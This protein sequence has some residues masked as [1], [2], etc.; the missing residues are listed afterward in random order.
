MNSV[1]LDKAKWI[2]APQEQP[3]SFSN[4]WEK[5]IF[6]S[7][8][9]TITPEKGMATFRKRF[10]CSKAVKS[11]S[12]TVT[13]LGVFDAYINGERVG[14][15]DSGG[16]ITYEEFKPGWTDYTKR[17]LSF[18]YDI[19]G[20]I[21]AGDNDIVARVARGWYAGRISF[22]YYGYKKRALL[23]AITIEY[24][25]G[26]SEHICSGEDWET[27][28]AG[29]V[30]FAEI[31]DGEYYDARIADCA[32]S[33]DGVT[34]AR[35]ELNADFNGEVTPAEEPHIRVRR[36]L[37][38]KPETAVLYNGVI[39]D[40]TDFGSINIKKT[41]AGSMC[42]RMRICKGDTLLLDFGQNMVGR[43]RFTLKAAS[44][45]KATVY[46]AEL[47]NDSGEL[48]RKNDGPKGSA[49]I[50]NYRTA[51]S[52]IVYIA[53]GEPAGEEYTPLYTFFG[54]RYIE[55][56]A[57][58]DLELCSITGEVIGSDTTETSWLITSN[59]EI[60]RLYSNILWG[61]R[62]NY[63][64]IPTDC[65]QRDE[66]LGWTGDTQI[67]CGAAAYNADV[68]AFFKKWLRDARDSQSE[69]GG[70]CDVIPRVFPKENNDSNA[71]WG[72]AG[73]IVPYKVYQAYGDKT[74][75][76]EHYPSMEKYMACLASYGLDGLHNAYGDW[77]AYE[78]TDRS[79]ISIACYAH[80]AQLMEKMSAVLSKTPGDYYD[81]RRAEYNRLF[82]DLKAEFACRFIS[83]G[84]LKETS[85]TAYLMAL[86]FN[87]LPQDM[88]PQA[89]AQL[90][91]KLKDNNYTLSTGFV[92]TGIINQTLSQYGLDG[93]AYSLLLQT[94]DPSWLYSVR[95]GATTIWERWNSY[96]LERG[97]GDVVMN[98]FNHYAYGAVCEW[99]FESMA[100]IA[101]DEQ[102]PGYKHFILSPRP[103]TRNDAELPFGQERITYVKAEYNSRAGLIKSSWEQKEDRFTYKAS[104]PQGAGATVRLPLAGQGTVLV[105]GRA[106]GGV[107]ISGGFAVF[108]LGAGEYTMETV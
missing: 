61:Q 89:V 32:K 97:F 36:G 107:T 75:I 38:R 99:M 46:F 108:E 21:T 45:V 17:V 30:M 80:N 76:S 34:W 83:G 81:T 72:D 103:D 26:S 70:Y 78:P 41:A 8:A 71:A 84:E 54:F 90:E 14:T 101:K 53:N 3:V 92:G 18:T 33:P 2:S 5:G 96:T 60:N 23:A 35:A 39:A 6:N 73:V 64:S 65:P 27:A 22:G 66:R 93:M 55:I 50:A 37:G 105:N 67:F 20:F 56:E 43:P 7:K 4:Q 11:A 88:V 106:L 63:L 74:I 40:G 91:K 77:L 94:A 58:G 68:N 85:Q 69:A 47:L 12:L 51:L 31:W 98:S 25:D 16:S 95:Q 42:E 62:G 9:M 87:L 52:R 29:P 48:E 82:A 1:F 86:R 24:A 13:A 28:I 59:E 15:K 104:I 100:G 79:Y 10:V 102:S 19:T 57:D 49:Y 44:G